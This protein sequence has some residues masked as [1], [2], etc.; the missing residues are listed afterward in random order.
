MSGSRLPA[1]TLTL[2]QFLQ[3]QRVLGLYRSLLRTIRE[4]PDPADRSYLRS[5]ARDEF[6]RNK[7]ATNPPLT[8]CWLQVQI[9]GG[10]GSGDGDPR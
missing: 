7:T 2:K 3:R 8:S 9:T 10:G 5:W 1:V 6:Q 4:V